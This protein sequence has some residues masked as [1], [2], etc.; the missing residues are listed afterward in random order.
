MRITEELRE[1][2]RHLK[3]VGKEDEAYLI[4]RKGDTAVI[5]NRGN[6]LF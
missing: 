4:K 3:S 5:V 2:V 1:M 6:I